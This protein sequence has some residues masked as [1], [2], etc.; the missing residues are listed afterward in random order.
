[1]SGSSPGEA[2]RPSGER[3]DFSGILA[4]GRWRGP[5]GIGR[6]ATE[7][8]A[9]LPGVRL[10]EG[11]ESLFLSPFDPIWISRKIRKERPRAYFTPAFNPPVFSPV[12]FVLTLHDLIHLKVPEEGSLLKHLYYERIVKPALF[13]AFRVLT[14]SEWSKGEI[15]AWSGLPGERVVVAG[16]GVGPSFSPEGPRHALGYPYFLYVGNRKPHKNLSLLFSAFSR[17]RLPREFRL[18]LSGKPDADM[19]D[20]LKRLGIEERVVFLGAIPE[21]SLPSVYRGAVALLFPS[22]IEGFGLPVLEALACGSRVLAS[23]IPAVVEGAGEAA[24]LLSPEDPEAWSDS[25]ERIAETI[26]D[27]KVEEPCE[28]NALREAGLARARLY[29]WDRVGE[30]VGAVLRQAMEERGQ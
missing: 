9:R 24:T 22:R 14:I 15:L 12:P 8:L 6:F 20:H 18:L 27:G 7:V 1:M 29:S 25:M 30:R 2:G 10:L 17:A 23:R 4:D 11:G 13:K 16:N 26:G 21:G 3:G 19:G 5:H 28:G